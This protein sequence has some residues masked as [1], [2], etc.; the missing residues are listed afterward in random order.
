MENIPYSGLNSQELAQDLP[1]SRCSIYIEKTCESTI[2]QKWQEW[3]DCKNVP[4]SVLLISLLCNETVWFLRAKGGRASLLLGPGLACDSSRP[5]VCSG[6]DEVL[7]GFLASRGLV[8]SIFSPGVWPQLSQQAQ[9]WRMRDCGR[10]LSKTAEASG[11]A[12]RAA[13]SPASQLTTETE[14]RP[15]PEALPS[16]PTVWWAGIHA[17][18]ESL[19]SGVTGYTVTK[20]WDYTETACLFLEPLLVKIMSNCTNSSFTGLVYNPWIMAKFVDRRRLTTGTT[21]E[22][23]AVAHCRSR[24]PCKVLPLWALLTAQDASEHR[25]GLTGH[26]REE[27]CKKVKTHSSGFCINVK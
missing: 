9:G 26:C 8:C 21:L 13:V 2:P 3:T 5:A 23:T 1:H 14:A 22:R 27:M 11:P 4:S 19:R 25:R 15:S 10:E 18:S 20:L 6:S 16:P 24:G 12:F 17:V 7:F